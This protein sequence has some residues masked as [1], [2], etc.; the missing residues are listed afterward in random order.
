MMKARFLQ[1]VNKTDSC[2]LWSGP[3]NAYGYGRFC[4]KYKSSMA[5]RT[6]Y[7]LFVGKI[8]NLYVCHKC[9]VRSCVNPKHLFLGTQKDNMKDCCNKKR[10]NL[11]SKNG[12]AR[13][14]Q[15]Q[16]LEIK[17]IGRCGDFTHLQIATKFK[18]SRSNVSAILSNKRWPHLDRGGDLSQI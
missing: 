17:R 15:D 7:E 9:D 5:H 2:W 1:Y 16:V 11:G 10:Q 3:I 14:T 18:T 13:L 12:M 8:E 4:Y 6:S